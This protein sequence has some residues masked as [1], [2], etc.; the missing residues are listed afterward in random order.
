ME[1]EFVHPMPCELLPPPYSSTI[2]L[3]QRRMAFGALRFVDAGLVLGAAVTQDIIR[4]HD[5]GSSQ[6]CINRVP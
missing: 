2:T 5:N 6:E 4:N 3:F 1:G